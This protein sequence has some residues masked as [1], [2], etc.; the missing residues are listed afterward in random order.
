MSSRRVVPSSYAGREGSKSGSLCP[1]VVRHAIGFNGC[2]WGQG[3]R[4]GGND[5]LG[6]LWISLPGPD[7]DWEQAEVVKAGVVSGC[8]L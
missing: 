5:A 6:S 8:C 3:K 1:R 2:Q 7:G 4:E